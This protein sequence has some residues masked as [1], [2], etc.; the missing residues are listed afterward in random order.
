MQGYDATLASSQQDAVESFSKREVYPDCILLDTE[1]EGFVPLSVRV[2]CACRMVG[3][4]HSPTYPPTLCLLTRPFPS[5]SPTH[6]PT[7]LLSF[8]R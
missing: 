6:P 1:A 3:H 5:Y 8:F 7:L 4:T 2:N